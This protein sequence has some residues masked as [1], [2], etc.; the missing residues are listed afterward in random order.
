MNEQPDQ[1]L[2]TAPGETHPGDIPSGDTTPRVATVLQV[3][4]ALGSSGGV[5]RGTVEIAEAIVEEAAAEHVDR[6]G[7]GDLIRWFG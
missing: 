5:E 3:L 1:T 7:D 6:V 4:P 2:N